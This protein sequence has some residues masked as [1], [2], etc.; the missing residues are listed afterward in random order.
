VERN[1]SDKRPSLLLSGMIYSRKKYTALAQILDKAANATL[2][3]R[4]S[5]FCNAACYKDKKNFKLISRLSCLCVKKWPNFCRSRSCE[6]NRNLA[7]SKHP[8][9]ESL[10]P[11]LVVMSLVCY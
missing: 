3:K 8:S 11:G 9:P 1:G 10:V 5:L 7:W 4:S 6:W 2:D